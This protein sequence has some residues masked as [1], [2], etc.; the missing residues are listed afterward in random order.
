MFNLPIFP[1]NSIFIVT[2]TLFFEQFI[3]HKK[4]F[5]RKLFKIL[6]ILGIW[7]N[8]RFKILTINLDRA[9][10]RILEGGSRQNYF[11]RKNSLPKPPSLP[12]NPRE[13]SLFVQPPQVCGSEEKA[14]ARGEV[15][16]RSITFSFPKVFRFR[17]QLPPPTSVPFLPGRGR[18]C[19][20]LLA[21]NIF[22]T[23][24]SWINMEEE[25]KGK[26][27]E[28]RCREGRRL[29]TNDEKC[30]RAHTKGRWREIRRPRIFST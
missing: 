5:P 20:V 30:R 17:G 4:E 24:A 8:P 13:G 18:P 3:Y 10:F 12:R 26:E 7:L 6:K 14:E 27:M 21:R 28:T 29:R 19:H 16:G 1:Y 2:Q 22:C 15:A 23:W 25:E 9:K 11:L